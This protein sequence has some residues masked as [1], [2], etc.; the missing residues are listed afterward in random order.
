MYETAE[1]PDSGTLMAR[2]NLSWLIEGHDPP[3]IEGAPRG[4]TR[5]FS[6]TESVLFAGSRFHGR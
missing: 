6:Q 2:F 4:A 1:H 5:R 3:G